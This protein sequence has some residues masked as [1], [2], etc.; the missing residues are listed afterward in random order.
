MNPVFS[1]R[2]G[3]DEPEEFRFGRHGEFGGA[4]RLGEGVA[5]NATAVFLGGEEAVAPAG[6]FRADV[7]ETF[8]ADNAFE[9]ESDFGD[10]SRDLELDG[11]VA[12]ILGAFIR[13]DLI[14]A[15]GN[16]CE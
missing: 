3:N 1:G 6:V 10:S 16:I 14:P 4:G 11:I 5:V 15:F 13:G 9:I 12:V 2:A 8:R 7:A